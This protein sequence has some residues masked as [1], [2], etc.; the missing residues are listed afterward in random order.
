MYRRFVYAI[1]LNLWRWEIRCDECNALLRCGTARTMIA[2]DRQAR[3]FV[4]SFD[5][6]I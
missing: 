2:A 6:T 4:N 3:H 1:E 5:A